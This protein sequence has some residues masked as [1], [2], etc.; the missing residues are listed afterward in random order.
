MTEASSGLK[1]V[2]FNANSEKDHSLLSVDTQR[3][4]R[5]EINIL[6]QNKDTQIGKQGVSVIT[7][8][9]LKDKSIYILT[10]GANVTQGMYSEVKDYL[11]NGFSLHV[12]QLSLPKMSSSGSFG[13]ESCVSVEYTNV[14]PIA[15]I[16]LLFVLFVVGL[17]ITP[18][19]YYLGGTMFGIFQ[20]EGWVTS[21]IVNGLATAIMLVLLQMIRSVKKMNKMYDVY[22]VEL[23]MSTQ[24]MIGLVGSLLYCMVCFL[25][26]TKSD[27]SMFGSV[28]RLIY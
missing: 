26:H 12:G 18:V 20:T 2:L 16:G 15:T 27:S 3:K 14:R 5:D 11:G 4:I 19:I 13:K 23:Q 28:L 10:D 1:R 8:K 25:V 24:M 6:L 9:H 7:E 22:V 21:I 17:Y